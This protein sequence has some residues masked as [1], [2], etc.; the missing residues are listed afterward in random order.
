MLCVQLGC[1][2]SLF[3]GYH[4]ISA[5]EFIYNSLNHGPKQ[6][7]SIKTH[8]VCV[9]RQVGVV[10]VQDFY[11]GDWCLCPVGNHNK[12]SVVFPENIMSFEVMTLDTLSRFHVTLF[13]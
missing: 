8:R 2:H 13:Q 12:P 9:R 4:T 11:P 7:G 6:R 1:F 10:I 5:L 3:I